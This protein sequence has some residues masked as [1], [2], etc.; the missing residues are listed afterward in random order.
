MKPITTESFQGEPSGGSAPAIH[1][2]RPPLGVTTS[3][4]FG[5][6]RSL[7]CGSSTLFCST[8]TPFANCYLKDGIHLLAEN[9]K[10]TSALHAHEQL[11]LHVPSKTK[12]GGCRREMTIEN[13]RIRSRTQAERM[14]LLYPAKSI[15]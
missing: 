3:K 10:R 7:M 15:K 4:Q 5:T 14:S 8:S 12:N 11:G 6:A 9:D 1:H 13:Y 2:R